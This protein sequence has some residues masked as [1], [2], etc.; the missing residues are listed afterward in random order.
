MS[1]VLNIEELKKMAT[2]IID[3]PDFEGTG[4]IKVRVQRPRIMAMAAQGKIP[5]ALMGAAASTVG[6]GSSKKKDS[7][8]N[9]LKDIANM[10]E[11][12]CKA[13]LVEPTYDEFKDIMTDEQMQA[14]FDW[15]MG[16]VRQLKS[17]RTDEGNG[18][19]NNDSKKVSKKTKRDTKD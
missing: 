4:T 2:S 6:L 3:I 10:M 5:N 11:L 12:Y 9:T 14:I 13:C 18:K 1:K 8:E 17:F 16:G 19:G 15:A 7:P